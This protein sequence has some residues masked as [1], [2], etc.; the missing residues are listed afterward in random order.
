[1]FDQ[2]IDY[3]FDQLMECMYVIP[4][5]GMYMFDQLMECICFTS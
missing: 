4:V 3:M 1:M 2:L 5:N